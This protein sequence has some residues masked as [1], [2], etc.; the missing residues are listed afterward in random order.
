LELMTAIFRIAD[1]LASR[2]E[3]AEP[4]DAIEWNV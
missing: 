2:G 1:T 3:K 4:K